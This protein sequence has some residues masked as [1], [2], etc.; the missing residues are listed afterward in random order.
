MEDTFNLLVDLDGPNPTCEVHTCK[1]GIQVHLCL[2]NILSL[3]HLH[4][5]K[6]KGNEPLIS[7]NQSHIITYN[8][9]L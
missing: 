2:A 4:A 6:T 3:S 8:E 7:Y 5:R 9:Y 1:N